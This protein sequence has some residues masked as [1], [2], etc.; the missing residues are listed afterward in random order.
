MGFLNRKKKQPESDEYKK[1]KTTEEI[2]NEQ[3]ET[4]SQNLQ[5]EISEKT[6]HLDSIIEK[7]ELTKK[8][9]Q[10]VISQT[11]SSKKQLLDI[12]KQIKSAYSD[13]DLAP[14]QEEH[15]RILVE[16]KQSNDELSKI[17]KELE[18]INPKK[19][20]FQK[21]NEELEQ[22]KKE[23]EIIKKQIQTSKSTIKKDGDNSKQI[24]E[25]ASQV[26]ATTKKKLNNTL[27]ELDMMKQILEKEKKSHNETKKK[28]NQQK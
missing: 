27:K 23:L 2:I 20:D 16:I 6:T 3:Q 13:F 21:V 17:K 11:M 10:G 19:L 28:L 15:Q 12:K 24:V 8:E 22:R 4:E 1:I 9:Y 26:I 25:S 5:T 18:Y 14:K 7:L